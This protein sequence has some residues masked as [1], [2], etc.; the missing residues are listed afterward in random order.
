MSDNQW[1]SFIDKLRVTAVRGSYDPALLSAYFMY[2][3]AVFLPQRTLSGFHKRHK[4][5]TTLNPNNDK[6][7]GIIVS[8]TYNFVEGNPL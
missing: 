5:L 6:D 2:R 1:L 3:T 8:N 4:A 7:Q